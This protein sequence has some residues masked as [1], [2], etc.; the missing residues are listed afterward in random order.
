MT[1]T[2]LR[3]FSHFFNIGRQ[4]SFCLLCQTLATVFTP[5]HVSLISRTE[6]FSSV[7]V[8]LLYTSIPS[9]CTIAPEFSHS[10]LAGGSAT[11]VQ[12]IRPL[13][14]RYRMPDD[15]QRS[16][17]WAA[18]PHRQHD[19]FQTT[20]KDTFFLELSTRLAHQRW[21]SNAL[22]KFTLLTYLLTL[23]STMLSG[24]SVCYF[25]TGY[26][27]ICRCG[28]CVQLYPPPSPGRY[29]SL[30]FRVILA[31]AGGWLQ[32]ACEPVGLYIA[33]ASTIHVCTRAIPENQSTTCIV[34]A[35]TKFPDI[36]NLP[37]YK[38]HSFGLSVSP[39]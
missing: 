5:V 26:W 10:S 4:S 38:S 29:P 9:C 17:R 30:C 7:P 34:T 36:T 16:A 11:S 8:G 35:N 3:F 28:K 1:L 21:R 2:T 19:K 32:A 33:A 23:L 39:Q 37:L 18:R 25:S 14:I 22:Y 31:C 6:I 20:F 27:S 12:H 13:G 15:L 24:K